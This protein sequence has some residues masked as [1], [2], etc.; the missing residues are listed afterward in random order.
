MPKPQTREE[1]I[2]YYRD[3]QRDRSAALRLIKPGKLERIRIT[4][5]WTIVRTPRGRERFAR[6]NIEKGGDR[7]FIPR[8]YDGR[9]GHKL[10]PLFDCYVFVELK[11][12]QAWMHLQYTPGVIEVLRNQ[13]KAVRCQD[14]LIHQLIRE[15]GAEGYLDLAPARYDPK[16]G[17]QIKIIAGLFKDHVARYVGRSP[18]LLMQAA[19]DFMGKEVRVDL[20]RGEIEKLP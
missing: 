2:R 4:T 11:I 1:A 19:L 12:D 13:G 9:F 5:Y 6:L 7:C 14:E 17:E 10:K 20:K 18:D 8:V 16:E 15:Q 3:R